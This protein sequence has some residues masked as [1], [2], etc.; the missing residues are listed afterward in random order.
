MSDDDNVIGIGGRATTKARAAVPQVVSM[1]EM[2]LE[3]AKSG[4]LRQLAFVYV[5]GTGRPTD[6]YGPGGPPE[7][8]IPIIGGLELCKAT[9]LSQMVA[10]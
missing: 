8:L 5:D 4:D 3:R 7:E 1:C 10:A 6:G 2:L 9:L